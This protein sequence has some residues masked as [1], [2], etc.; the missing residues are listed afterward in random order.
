[1][2][3]EGQI[4][5][6]AG[7]FKVLKTLATSSFSN[8]YLV[9]HLLSHNKY[10]MKAIKNPNNKA[11]IENEIDI[12]RTLNSLDEV[13]KLV[14]VFYDE[15]K[16]FFVYELANQGTLEKFIENTDFME[17][18]KIID[19]F[20]TLLKTLKVIHNHDILH[21]DIKP[22]NIIV[23]DNKFYFCDFGLS[24][25]NKKSVDLVHLKTDT[26]Y[27]A[28]EVYHGVYNKAS[29]IYALGAT[30]YYMATKSQVFNLSHKD[31]ESYR[32]LCHTKLNIDFTKI[33]SKKI[34]YLVKR[35]MDKN[36]RQRASIPELEYILLN[37]YSHYEI[38]QE[39]LDYT[40]EKIRSD[41]DIY[42]EL[43]NDE[44]AF[45]QNALAG[46]LG[47]ENSVKAFEY[48]KKAA[49]NGLIKAYYNLGLCFKDGIGCQKDMRLA[50]DCFSKAAIQNHE[51][52][53]FMVGLFYEH[54]VYVEQDLEKA[55][56][57]YITSAFHG[58]KKA[59]EKLNSGLFLSKNKKKV[60]YNSTSLN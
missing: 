51:N 45:A 3:L 33:K 12:N 22:D 13:L 4:L 37:D 8:V 57:L 14:N 53:V 26:V 10:A 56:Q 20:S 46:L 7:D 54:G 19:I 50:F 42:T 21:H 11:R 1:M 43:A 30:L 15:K 24:F 41:L 31:N 5:K 29:D 48:Y 34:Q 38:K 6:Q 25:K 27:A 18:K 9:E 23:K 36:H 44:I 49:A 17:E 39:S 47:E 28:P 32:M 59:Y 16:L 2:I 58:N 52:A 40:P 60:N 35:M 55:K